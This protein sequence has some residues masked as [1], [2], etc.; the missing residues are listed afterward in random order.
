MIFSVILHGV[1][2]APLAARYG[3]M[4]AKQTLPEEREATAAGLYVHNAEDAPRI[5]AEELAE[6]LA[7]PQPPVVPDV[8]SRSTYVRDAD[9]IPGSIRVLPDQVRE[10][11]AGQPKDRKMVAYCT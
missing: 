6:Q 11:A 3:R 7:G 2:A 10:W 4:V 8:R 1:S 5:S 9:Q